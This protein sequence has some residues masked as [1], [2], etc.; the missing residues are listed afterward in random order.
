[1][2]KAKSRWIMFL[3][4]LQFYRNSE[5]IYTQD[6]PLIFSFCKDVLERYREE[7]LPLSNNYRR[8]LFKDDRVIDA[9][10]LGSASQVNSSPKK[11]LSQIT[12][13]AS[14][15]HEKC[16]LL[17]AIARWTKSKYILELGTNTGLATMAWA[18]ADFDIDTVEGNPQLFELS[19]TSL[20]KFSN[21]VCFN[22]TFSEF[23][24]TNT[25]K[26][27]LIYI[28]GDHSFEATYDLVQKSKGFLNSNGI[29]ILDDIR[30]SAEMKMIWKECIRNFGF[31]LAIDLF[32]LGILSESADLKTSI[33]KTL[34]PKKYKPWPYHFFR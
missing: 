6:S 10:C 24:A 28:D 15:Y 16:Q 27:D 30:W 26:Y 18:E 29:I 13:S 14:S 31:N 25:D 9:Y 33:H 34:I 23:L 7:D 21:V 17:V 2:L 12:K 5:T 3:D 11:S 19:S 20:K 22:S 8:S 1:M 32:A 4:F